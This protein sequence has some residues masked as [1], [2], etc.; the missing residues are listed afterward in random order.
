MERIKISGVWLSKEQEV[1]TGIVYAF[2]RL[3][4]EDSKWKVDIGGL[5]LNQI[6]QQEA[7]ILELPFMEEEVHSTLMDI[8]GDKAP[9]PNG[10]TGAFWQFCWEFVKEEV[11]EMFKEF[12]EQNVFLKSLN[13]T[14][15][16]LIPKKGG[17]EELGDFRPISLLG[18]LYKLLAKVLANRIKNVIG[19]VVSSDQNAFVMGRQI[20]D[21]SLIANEVID[22]WKKKERKA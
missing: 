5:N 6:S 20:L 14:F 15:L 2:Q 4:T 21:A 8:N 9:G 22:S 3:L 16:V 7:D 12:H 13:T 10:F 1:R 17:A 18:G 19:R 11:L